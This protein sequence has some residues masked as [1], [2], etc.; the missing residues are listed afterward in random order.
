[1]GASSNIGGGPPRSAKFLSR[2]IFDARANWCSR[3]GLTP[4]I[5][6]SG[7][8]PR[9]LPLPLSRADVRPEVLITSICADRTTTITG[10]GAYREVETS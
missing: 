2:R 6:L 8:G 7:T 10:A 1:M 4:S 3:H 9:T 5:S